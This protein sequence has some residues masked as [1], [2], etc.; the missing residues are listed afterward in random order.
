MSRS[1]VK[2]CVTCTRPVYHGNKCSICMS[3]AIGWAR[4]NHE[5]YL[6]MPRPVCVNY[7]DQA[8]YRGD[9]IMWLGVRRPVAWRPARIRNRCRCGG[10]ALR[11]ESWCIPCRNKQHREALAEMYKKV[12]LCPDFP[13][14]RETFDKFAN[15]WPVGKEFKEQ[16][17]TAGNQ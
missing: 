4:I 10:R 14:F 11:K 16:Y 12:S 13:E 8:I 1:T 17:D 9:K 2:T 3:E 15:L 6:K 7:P 5:N